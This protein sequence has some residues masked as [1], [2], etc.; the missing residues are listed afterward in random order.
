[1]DGKPSVVEALE[2]HKIGLIQKHICLQKSQGKHALWASVVVMITNPQLNA[3]SLDLHQ[4]WT[5]STRT[6]FKGCPKNTKAHEVYLERKKAKSRFVR[7]GLFGINIRLQINHCTVQSCT[8][9]CS[10]L[11]TTLKWQRQWW[12]C[13]AAKST[14]HTPTINLR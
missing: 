1:M 6:I 2:K 11:Q 12:C 14:T 9:G 7:R 8:A 10:D 3:H 4:L 5:S 13:T